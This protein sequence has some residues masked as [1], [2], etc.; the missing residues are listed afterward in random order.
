MEKGEIMR[1]LIWHV[2]Y[3]KSTLTQKGRSE[4]IEDKIP[5]IL[6]VKDAIVVFTSVEKSDESNVEFIIQKTSDEILKVCLQLK[7]NIIVIHS[8][9]HLFAEKLADPAIA[10]DIMKKISVRLNQP[11]YIIH[12]SPF[13]WFSELE[14]K[15]KGHPLSRIAR[16]IN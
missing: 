1:I 6:E 12:R 4:I 3:F 14:I 10:L 8:F 11:N 7:V 15:A 9:A 13:G 16:I 5:A 2:N